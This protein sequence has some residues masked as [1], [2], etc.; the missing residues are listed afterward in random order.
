MPG[1]KPPNLWR[2]KSS[3]NPSFLSYL[4]GS[5]LLMISRS[6]VWK[7][8][9]GHF[10]SGFQMWFWSVRKPILLGNMSP[11]GSSN[12]VHCN[13]TSW[14][15]K[16][17][18]IGQCIEKGPDEV[19]CPYFRSRSFQGEGLKKDSG[20]ISN[21]ESASTLTIN[22]SETNRTKIVQMLYTEALERQKQDTR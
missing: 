6:S 13:L 1:N 16:S 11:L 2:K 3:D 21:S 8:P 4:F 7:A 17:I 22:A 15:W 12:L 5:F 14:L 9:Y 18:C 19:R 10:N 20:L